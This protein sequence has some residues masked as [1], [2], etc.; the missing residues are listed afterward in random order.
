VCR[1]GSGHPASRYDHIPKPQE[2]PSLKTR[3]A[4]I[5]VLALVALPAFAQT[6]YSNGPVNGTTDGWTVNSGFVVSD[7]FTVGSGGG[8][9]TGFNFYA[10]TFPGDVLEN[11]EVAITS[12]EFGGTT[13][14]DQIVNFTQSGCSANQ[15]GYNVCLESSSGMTGVSLGAGTYWLN[16]ENAVV[17]DGDPI[18]WDE[19]SGPSSASENSIGT[20]PSEAFTVLGTSTTTTTSTTG[21]T[22]EPSSI[23]LLGSGALGLAG[24][25][26]RKLF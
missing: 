10:W 13:Y 21:G 9:V 18:F 26:R 24:V 16:L 5:A 14:S 7:T 3:V 11:A 2:D 6:L 22:P 19:N 12:S 15:Y 4:L 23:L 25:L 20:I 1:L 8:T 17:N